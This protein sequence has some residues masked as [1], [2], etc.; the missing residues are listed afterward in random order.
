MKNYQIVKKSKVSSARIGKIETFNGVVNTP[1]FMPVG[2]VGAVKTLSPD[3]LRNL[4]TEIILGNTYHLHLRPGEKFIRKSGGLTKFNLWNG[5]ILTDSG[6]YQVFSL[7]LR[8]EVNNKKGNNVKISEKGVIF[9]SHLDGSLHEF[10]PEKVIDIQLDLG[11]DI[12]MILDICTEFPATYKRAKE[13]M[14]L[15][16]L[17]AKRAINYW[18]KKPLRIRKKHKI[19]SIS[20]GSTYQDLRIESA[21]FMSKLTFDG[22]AVGG[23]SVGEGTRNMYNVIKWV[24]PYLDE[25][26]PH[27][28]MGVGEPENLIYAIKYGFDMFD[29]VLPT[30]LARHGVVWNR[31]SNFQFPISKYKYKKM[32]LRRGKC[33]T[34]LK[35]ISEKCGCYTCQNKF[36][37]AYLSHLVKEHE[38]LAFRLL[39]IHN[40][41]T[42]FELVKNIREEIKDGKY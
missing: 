30:R 25:N 11:S 31:N 33:K 2:T 1:V 13:A 35:P 38:I 26:K 24:G 19:F 27:Y 29:C 40:I 4:G 10:T 5:P 12:I 34:E 20:Q 41:Y 18:N 6:G 3:D 42:L 36:T 17:W 21:K 37:R 16:H 22:L 9:K 8:D 39:T 32:D 23:V 14:E 28:L 15:T 7:G